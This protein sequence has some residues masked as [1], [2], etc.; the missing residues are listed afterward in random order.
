MIEHESQGLFPVFLRSNTAFFN[1]ASRHK[2]A[3]DVPLNNLAVVASTI[4]FN[5]LNALS[6]KPSPAKV[7]QKSGTVAGCR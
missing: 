5:R 2:A 1:H 3:R 4:D 6:M 7:C